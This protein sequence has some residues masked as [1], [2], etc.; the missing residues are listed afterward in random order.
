MANNFANRSFNHFPIIISNVLFN[1]ISFINATYITIDS[2]FF[3]YIAKNWYLSDKFYRIM[4][5]I[6]VSK[7]FIAS[8]GQ[9]M[10]YIRDIK[11]KTI[12]IAKT[13]SIYV[14]FD[15]GSISFIESIIIQIFIGHIEFHIVKTNTLFLLYLT[16]LDWLGVYFININNSLII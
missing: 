2:N 7:H 14:L 3:A 5:K 9:F 10:T 13:S 11:D 15:I 12:N 4:I 16:N 1:H 8:Y 6:D